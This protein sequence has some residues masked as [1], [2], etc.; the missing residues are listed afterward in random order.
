MRQVRGAVVRALRD[1]PSATIAALAEITGLD[2]ERVAE[3]VRRM[4]DEGLLESRRGR[5]RL[6]P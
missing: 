4:T 3:A 5:A 1:R 2:A 6:A